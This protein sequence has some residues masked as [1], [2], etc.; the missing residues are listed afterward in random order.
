MVRAMGAA[1]VTETTTNKQWFA[2]DRDG[3]V[4]FQSFCS[5]NVNAEWDFSRWYL[6]LGRGKIIYIILN[7]R[8]LT[9]C[10]NFLTDFPASFEG[11]G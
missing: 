4:I 8:S 7:G 6:T 10:S 2:I 1:D 3:E 11:R 9:N 5:R